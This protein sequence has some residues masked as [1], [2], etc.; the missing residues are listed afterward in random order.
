LERKGILNPAW[1]TIINRDLIQKLLDAAMLPS[2]AAIVHYW[3]HQRMDNT[4][5]KAIILLT[6]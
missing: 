2:Q 6:E 4:F 1:N 3:R 5:L